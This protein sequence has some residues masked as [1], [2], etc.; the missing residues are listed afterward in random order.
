MASRQSLSAPSRRRVT[1]EN[2]RLL[3]QGHGPPPSAQQSGQALPAHQPAQ[4]GAM[5]A[6]PALGNALLL[7]AVCVWAALVY[8]RKERNKR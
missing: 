1:Y 4:E 8:R 6:D 3:R 7:L 5:I 2:R